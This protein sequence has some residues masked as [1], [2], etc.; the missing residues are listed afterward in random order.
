MPELR[1]FV[2]D[3]YGTLFDVHSVIAACREVTSDPEG[4]S[5]EWRAKQ[6]EYT[7]LRALLGRYEDFWEVTGA[8]LRFALQRMKVEATQAQ[9]DRLMEA[10]LNLQPFPEV[11]ETLKR[12]HGRF[13]LAILSN[14]SPRMLQAAARSS[15]LQP[16]LQHILSVDV[17]RTYK[18]NP[19]VYELGPRAL[20]LPKDAIAFVS[21]NAFDVIGAKAFGYRVIWCNRAQALLDPLGF[22]PDATV[23]RLDEI[24]G[25]LRL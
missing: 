10:Y 11:P 16:Y 14:G 17:I 4:L 22:L 13:P 25:V 12:L 8:A 18:P 23:A 19:T 2:F 9:V 15:G 3:A 5:R 24:P 6:L 20:G 7:W 21:S 1:A